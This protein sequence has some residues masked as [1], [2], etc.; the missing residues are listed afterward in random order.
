M[1]DNHQPAGAT[2]VNVPPWLRRGQQIFVTILP[3]RKWNSVAR[4]P[5]RVLEPRAAIR[6]CILCVYIR[7]RWIKWFMLHLGETICAVYAASPLQGSGKFHQR[8]CGAWEKG[9]EGTSPWFFTKFV[10]N[11][12]LRDFQGL[13]IQKNYNVETQLQRP[14]KKT[15]LPAAHRPL[16]SISVRTNVLGGQRNQSEWLWKHNKSPRLGHVWNSQWKLPSEDTLLYQNIL[17]RAT[18][19]TGAVR[20]HEY[21]G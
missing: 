1:T 20:D 11:Y 16:M 7:S 17:M 10:Q 18:V 3:I 12:L 4:L 21:S 2:G 19:E 13:R 14:S 5:E 15:L 9:L 6:T 8:G